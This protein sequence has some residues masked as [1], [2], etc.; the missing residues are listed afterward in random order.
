MG[1]H[2]YA[3]PPARAQRSRV[4]AKLRMRAAS[5]AISIRPF[6]IA[7]DP[8]GLVQRFPG[9]YPALLESGSQPHLGGEATFDILPIASG[10]L[11]EL[12]Q[13]E[14]AGPH[15]SSPRFLDAMEA[16][17]DELRAPS[18][19]RPTSSLPFVGG[20]LMYLSY[21]IAAEVE[22]RLRLPRCVDPLLALAIRAPAAWIRDRRRNRAYLIAESGYETLTADFERDARRARNLEIRCP[23]A[24]A[25]EEEKPE[26]FLAA[27]EKALDYIAMG[28]VYQ[29]NLSRVWQGE[30]TV[31]V[32]PAG[33]FKTLRT[34][35]PSPFAALLRHKD[36]AVIS[37]SPERLLSIRDRS[38]STRPI[39]G[40][41]PRGATVLEDN[42]LVRALLDNEKERAEHVMLIDLE[43]NDLGRVCRGGTVRVDQYM[44]V[45]TYAHVHHIVSSISGELRDDCTPIS[46]LRALF[47][48][49]TI[50]G[51]PKIRCMEIIGELEARG[52]GA[53]T[54]SVGYLN[55]DGSC[56]FNILI[57]TITLRGTV[58][59]FRAGAGIV[60]DSNA[61]QE[62]DETRAKAKGLLNAL[63]GTA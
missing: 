58:V 60:A 32:P 23:S 48:G 29:V 55:R 37:S 36:F 52:R 16:W 8:L 50:T 44:G 54:G 56:D 5:A 42:E 11:L 30:S 26:K 6:P 2:A 62:L 13:R 4:T 59:Q 7:C 61:S 22:T 34:A 1:H 53:Y 49:G 38:V 27:V 47:P 28:D 3:H 45:E 33:L 18:L 46:A 17:W 35:N 41:R 12:T 21:E 24:V 14:L 15:A 19:R 25:M 51:C 20:W 9:R 31:D 63:E 43:R 57:R 10:E 39:A 40:T